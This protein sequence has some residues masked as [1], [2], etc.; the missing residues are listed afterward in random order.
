M[1]MTMIHVLGGGCAQC[2]LHCPPLGS[3]ACR[4]NTFVEQL[5]SFMPGAQQSWFFFLIFGNSCR[6]S[7]ARHQY[8]LLLFVCLLFVDFL[9]SCTSF[10]PCASSSDIIAIPS[11]TWLEISPQ[12]SCLRCGFGLRVVDTTDFDWRFHH[13]QPAWGVVLVWVWLRL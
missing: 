2:F 5:N 12:T 3:R 11:P 7:T 13:R 9:P 1:K 4:S 10:P 6:G 8:F